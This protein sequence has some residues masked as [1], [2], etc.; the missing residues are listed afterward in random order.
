VDFG[1]VRRASLDGSTV[2]GTFGYMAPEQL[3][4]EATPASDVYALGATIAALHVGMEADRLPHDGLR[5][6]IDALS[7]SPVLRHV[8]RGMLQPEPRE[9]LQ[10]VAEVRRALREA[11]ESDAPLPRDLPARIPEPSVTL[12]APMRVLASV[13]WPLSIVVWA[14]TSVGSGALVI[15]EAVVLPLVSW[16]A[17]QAQDN[18]RSRLGQARVDEVRDNVR[19]VRRE[20]AEVAARTSPVRDRDGAPPPR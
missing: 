13:P 4:G 12:P 8:L 2:V 3:H 5:I 14:L 11:I 6:D 17:Y 18:A 20:L 9:R 10:S 16:I 1:G 15:V 19:Q 7:L